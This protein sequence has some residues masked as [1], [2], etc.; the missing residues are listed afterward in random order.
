MKLFNFRNLVIIL[1]LINILLA[2]RWIIDGNI[3]FHTDIARDFLLLEDIADNKNPVL[4]GPRSGAIPGLFHGPLWLYLNLPAYLLGNGDPVYVGWFWVLLYIVSLFST[5]FVGK[6]IFGEQEGLLAALLLSSVTILSVRSLFN[7]YGALILLPLFFYFLSKYLKDFKLKNLVIT[8]FILGFII[9]FQMA[10]GVPILIL[11]VGYLLYHLFKKKKLAHMI[12]FLVILIPLSSF[13]LFDLRNNF[14]Q[15]N[16]VKSYVL[17][18]QSHGK[19]DLNFSQLGAMRVKELVFD[20]LGTIT[21]NNFYL[22]VILL[23]LFIVGI[24]LTFKKKDLKFSSLYILGTFFYLGFWF[25]TILFKGPVWNYYYIPFIPL[26]ILIFVSLRNQ[27]NKIIFYAFFILIYV[28]NLQ[29]AILDINAYERNPLKQDVS[30]WRFN[31]MAAEGVF[32]GSDNE[33]GYFIFTPDLYGYSPR[34]AMNLLQKKNNEKNVSPYQKKG[35]TYLIIAP[36]PAYGKDP[37]SI[38]YQ[39]NTNSQKWKSSDIRINKEPES[40]ILFENGFVIEKYRL[41]DEEI[42][43]ESNPYLIKDIFFR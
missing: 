24:Y 26:L 18:S 38:W 1:I 10:F 22:T 25:L 29:T 8:F 6:K 2:S 5:Y 14:I 28:I 15:F 36:P 43:I 30:T 4:I 17:G 11:A 9:Q 13:L 31:K 3:F 39:K 34:Y 35:V 37:N 23:I 41:S 40:K 21:Q 12:S 19:L 33:F 27:I 7:P 16:S 42:K 20:G 32:N